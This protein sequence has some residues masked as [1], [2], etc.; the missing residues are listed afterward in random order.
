[1]V[2]RIVNLPTV[3][4]W[5]GTAGGAFAAHTV[6]VD[7]PTGP[8]YHSIWANINPGAG[9]TLTGI[10]NEFRLKVNGKV[11]RSMTG[12]ELNKLN[13]LNGIAY[14]SRGAYT[15]ATEFSLPIWLAEPWRNNPSAVEGTAWG[16]GDVS[17]FQLEVDIIAYAA[18]AAGLTAPTFSAIVDDSVI[19]LDG[20]AVPRP[21]GVITKWFNVQYPIT[22][23]S[24]YH[25]F[26]G[27]PKRDFYQSIHLIDANVDEF[28]VKVD[29]TIY[30]QDTITRNKARL[31]HREMVPD[32]TA[33]ASPVNVAADMPTRGMQ[34]I[35]FD[36]DD[37]LDS[38]L[39]MTYPSG[40]DVKDFNLRVKTG[41]G[42]AAPRNIKTIYQLAGAAE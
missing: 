30:R 36:E 5:I 18:A 37:R 1:M 23:L 20:R 2:K 13:I 35:V 4:G 33:T 32:P 40:R 8:T 22:A 28:E 25:D 34:D 10:F 12:D 7:I 24:S 29:N 16:T 38:A 19:T 31:Y 42:G 41:A 3:S 14:A 15:A 9:K 11:Q 6:T 26:T 39:P 21:L 17:T 27:L